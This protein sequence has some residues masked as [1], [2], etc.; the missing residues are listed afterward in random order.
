M[1]TAIE[2]SDHGQQRNLAQKIARVLDDIRSSN[3]THIRKLKDLSALRASSPVQFFEA[4]SKAII[5]LFNFQRRTASAERIVKFVSLFAFTPDAKNISSSDGFLENFLRFLLLAAEAAN[6]TARFRACQIISEIIIRLPDDAEVSSELWDEVIECMKLR[7]GDKVPVVRSFAVRAL[8]RFAN[9]SENRDII[10]LFLLALPLEQNADVRKTIVLSLPPSNETLSIIIE[11]TLDVSESVRKAAFCVIASKFPLQ[12]LSIKLRTTMLQRGLAD[13]ST[14]VAKECLKLMKDEW[15]LQCCNR[16]P[17][18]LLKFLDVETYESVGESVMATLL[19]EGL[20]SLQDGQ[21]IR[22]FLASTSDATEED[23]NHGIQLMEAEV[24]L[25]WRMVCKHL[26]MEASA[27]G[28]DAAMTTG[29]EAAVYAAEASDHNDLLDSVLP[30]TVS[31]YVELVNAHIAAGPNYRFASRQL[32]LLGT[33]LDFSDASNRKVASAFVQELLHRPLDH[34]MD[35][36]GVE[37]VIGDGINLGGERDWAAAVAELAKKVHA[38]AGEFEKVVLGVVEELARPCRERTADCKQWLHCLAAKHGH[39]DVQRAAIRCLGLFGLLERKP[40]EVLVRQLRCSFVKGPSAVTIMASKA[41]LDLGIWHG[42]HEVDNAMS[43]NLSSQLRDHRMAWTPVDLSNGSQGLDIELLDLL[44]AGLERQDWGAS[45]EVDENESIQA[46]LGEGLAKILLLSEKFPG[47]QASTYHLLLAKLIILYFCSESTELQRLKQC[48]S[49]FFEHYPSLSVNHKKCISKA[50]MPVMRSLWPGING[51]ATGSTIMVSNMRKRAVQASRFML[52]MMQV[53]LYAKETAPDENDV[54][55]LDNQADPSLD[56]E[57]GEE[58]LAIRIAVEVASFHAKKTSAEKSYL[59]A[60]CRILVLLQFR[61]SE[62]GAIKLVR[63]LLNRVSESVAAE[64]DL[65]KELRQMAERLKE[66]D[67]HPDQKLSSDQTNQIL[68]RLELEINLEEDDTMEVPLTPAVQS[69]RPGRARRRARVEE[70]SSS[71][72]ELSPTSVAPT[73]PA[74]MSTRSQ[75][76]SKTAALT[77]MTAKQTVK[78]DENDETDDDDSGSE[79]TSE[80]DS[81]A[82]D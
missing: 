80:D 41:L 33:M 37:V 23:C 58:G 44:Y 6:K 5:P 82:F 66:L 60:V 49:V 63:Q 21:T 29:A 68:G 45:A 40:S 59:S 54:E 79:V 36:S 18:E 53:P 3:A 31:E 62:Q 27:K 13:R 20:V 28:S 25:Y 24:A 47:V 67:G 17:I 9:E 43:C 56:F 16:D 71:D 2:E 1:P 32:L 50:F 11:S 4:F 52:Q 15:L 8:L 76:A 10:D 78:I 19:K 75:R 61:A 74:V 81:D 73:N 65:L 14:A 69:T 38:A 22:Q 70:E 46:I 39:L 64:K 57:S 26:Q 30:A 12:T 72:D 48:L 55:S 34:E 42:P 7:V 51:N 35:D 77:K